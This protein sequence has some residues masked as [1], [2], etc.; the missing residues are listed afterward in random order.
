M[1]T[2]SIW[3]RWFSRFCRLRSL[4]QQQPFISPSTD[5]K[6]CGKLCSRCR[7]LGL[8]QE[9]F[10]CELSEDD[11]DKYGV[12]VFDFEDRDDGLLV[13][14]DYIRNLTK[15]SRCLFCQL[16]LCAIEEQYQSDDRSVMPSHQ[17][18]LEWRH[19]PCKIKRHAEDDN[20]Y[21]RYIQVLSP[22]NCKDEYLERGQFIFRSHPFKREV[23]RSLIAPVSVGNASEQFLMGRDVRSKID[24]Q[25]LKRWMQSC[26]NSHGDQCNEPTGEITKSLPSPFFMVVDVKNMCLSAPSTPYRYIT[27]SYVWGGKG[28]N[29][30]LTTNSN[31]GHLRR[32]RALMDFWNL[33]PRTVQ[34]AITLVQ[35]LGERYLW[36]DSLW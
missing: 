30:F 5:H 29:S 19:V 28:Q 34:D 10:Y 35:E 17:Y 2:L 32:N 21:V 1:G 31:V 33:L 36:I 26:E 9:F 25:L 20:W 16:I 27:L 4:G 15:T 24:I 23:I 12:R 11:E 6:T 8:G 13:T 3:A 7:K 22:A 14:Q 18:R